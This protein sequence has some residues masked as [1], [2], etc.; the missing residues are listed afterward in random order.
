MSSEAKTLQAIK[1]DRE[2]KTLDILDQLLIPYATEYISIKSIEDAYQAIKLMQVRGAPAIAIVGAFSIVV[3]VYN[4]LKETKEKSR[5]IGDL[6]ESIHYLI[7]ARP[8]AVNLS[9][10]CLDIEKLILTEFKRTNWLTSIHLISY[11]NILLHYTMMT[12][13]IISRLV[14]MDC[15]ILS[16]H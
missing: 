8:T 1:F 2:T 4:N 3:D 16:K 12:W 5:T 14:I 10:A 9:N 15:I 7:T 6:V 13:I 11:I